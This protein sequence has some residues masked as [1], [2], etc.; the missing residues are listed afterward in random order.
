MKVASE[1]GKR[2]VAVS[3]TSCTIYN[4]NGLDIEEVLKYKREKG[5][6]TGF[7]GGRELPRDD[8]LK[9][10]VDIL[11]PAAVENV[12]TEENWKE[13]K[14]KLILELA[15]GPTQITI[16]GKL[17]EK[18]IIVIP[19]VLANAGGVVVSYLEWVQNRTGDRWEEEEIRSKLKTIMTKAFEEVM[20]RSEENNI[21]LRR[22]SYLVAVDRIIEAAKLRGEI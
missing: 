10:D 4:E 20:T 6:L 1:H 22:G 11:V 17:K 21:D 16:D 2:I 14:A 19:D 12:I 5:K 18:G 8:I 7:S 3:D 9:L 13:I 15:N